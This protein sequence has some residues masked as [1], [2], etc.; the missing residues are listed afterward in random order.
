[1]S[2]ELAAQSSLVVAAGELPEYICK[3]TG[4][5]DEDLENA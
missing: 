3:L 5:L 2:W 1:M 4:V